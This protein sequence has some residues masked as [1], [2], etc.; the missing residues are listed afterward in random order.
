MKTAD[1]TIHILYALS[2]FKR[3]FV[4]IDHAIWKWYDKNT[5]YFI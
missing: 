2:S 5:E 1:I 3:G 4:D